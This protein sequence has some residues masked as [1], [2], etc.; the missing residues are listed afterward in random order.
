M[1]EGRGMSILKASF[2]QNLTDVKKKEVGGWEKKW[3]EIEKHVV[4]IDKKKNKT[5][6]SGK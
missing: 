1:G 4:K 5:L 6:K 2:R 3:Q